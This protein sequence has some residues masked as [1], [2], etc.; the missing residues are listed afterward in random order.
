MAIIIILTNIAWNS[1]API[2]VRSF[3]KASYFYATHKWVK[4]LKVKDKDLEMI[5]TLNRESTILKIDICNIIITYYCSVI[6]MLFKIFLDILIHRP[7]LL[8]F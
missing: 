8:S 4:I 5:K 3:K 7:I 2:E 6:V 1:H